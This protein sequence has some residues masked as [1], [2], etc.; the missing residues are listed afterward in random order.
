MPP[1]LI[2]V[3]F[4]KAAGS[5]LRSAYET[6]FGEDRVL[7]DYDNDPVDPCGLINLHPTR[8]EETRPTSLGLYAAVHGHFHIGRYSQI[9]NAVRTVVLRE[10]IDNMISIYYF[11]DFFRQKGVYFEHLLYRHFFDSRMNLLELATI[12]SLRNLM[13]ESYFRDTDMRCFDVIGDFADLNAYLGRVMTLT[14]AELVTIPKV[15]VTPSSDERDATSEDTHTLA[16]LRDL[17]ANDLRFY[18]RHCNR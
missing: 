10:P 18:E 12:P 4:P 16:R 5:S 9:K 2:S 17:L 14:G 1:K 6:A 15:N 8:Y 11:W 7:L 13:S 3:H